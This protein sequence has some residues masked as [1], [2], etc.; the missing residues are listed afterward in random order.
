M[1]ELRL[2]ERNGPSASRLA[3][4]GDLI[5]SPFRLSVE[6][7]TSWLLQGYAPWGSGVHCSVPREHPQH[8]FRVTWVPTNM[9]C[10]KKS[11]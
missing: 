2:E 10:L 8:N 4:F 3:T 5:V 11:S 9:T 7:S 1:L 6:A